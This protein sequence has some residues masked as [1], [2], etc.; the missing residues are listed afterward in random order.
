MKY[1]KNVRDNRI[2]FSI[3]EQNE[4]SITVEFSIPP[5]GLYK[6]GDQ[7]LIS[8][9]N[10]MVLENINSNLIP[11]KTVGRCKVLRAETK[12]VVLNY[13]TKI[14]KSIPKAQ[15][16]TEEQVKHTTRRKNAKPRLKK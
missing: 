12:T 4:N 2:E 5:Y 15:K 9:L 3:S 14:K 8:E 11:E 10:N 16:N 6:R 1:T 13:K 7:I